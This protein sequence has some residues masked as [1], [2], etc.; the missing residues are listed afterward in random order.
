MKKIL[1]LLVLTL[2]IVGSCVAA[3]SERDLLPANPFEWVLAKLTPASTQVSKAPATAAAVAP[4]PTKPA[5]DPVGKIIADSNQPKCK[6]VIKK[7]YKTKIIKPKI[8]KVEKKVEVTKS[9][10]GKVIKTTTTTT[11][12]FK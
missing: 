12:Y 3:T 10:K 8:E 2:I 1:A 5:D 4:S 7:V 11:T 9:K 6:P